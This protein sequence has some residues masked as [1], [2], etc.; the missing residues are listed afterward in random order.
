MQF[1]QTQVWPMLLYFET[2]AALHR[3]V[4]IGIAEHHEGRVAAELEF[5]ASSRRR[6]P[7]SAA[8]LRTIARCGARHRAARSRR[9]VGNAPER[10]IHSGC[11]A[12]IGFAPAD[13]ALGRGLGVPLGRCRAGSVFE[14]GGFFRI[15]PTEPRLRA[16]RQ[17]RQRLGDVIDRA[18][19]V[20]RTGSRKTNFIDARRYGRLN[21]LA[22]PRAGVALPFTPSRDHY[23][24]LAAHWP[25]TSESK[26]RSAN[27]DLTAFSTLY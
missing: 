2:I 24:P 9:S 19:R 6:K 27:A 14:I 26:V 1:A 21:V 12:H 22:A 10:Q 4:A 15:A 11:A 25:Q 13:H 17:R 23:L 5:R 20:Q 16:D 18:E 7:F 8:Q 3:G